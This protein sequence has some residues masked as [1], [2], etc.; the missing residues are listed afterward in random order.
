MFVDIQGDKAKGIELTEERVRTMAESRLRAARLYADT[1]ATAGGMI[2]GW[3]G[4]LILTLDDGPAFT[5]SVAYSKFL[6][7]PVTGRTLMA[8][9][10]DTRRVAGWVS[11]GVPSH[12]RGLVR[13]TPWLGP[14]RLGPR[15][16]PC[17]SIW[18]GG[19]LPR[20]RGRP[21]D[22]GRVI[23]SRSRG[24]TL[25]ATPS[26]YQVRS[27]SIEKLRE[28]IAVEDPEFATTMDTSDIPDGKWVYN[29]T[30]EYEWDE[31]PREV[32]ERYGPTF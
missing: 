16:C 20:P 17:A 30:W 6:R 14:V 22:P 12:E 25:R 23:A 24:G 1:L 18:C 27:H 8:M 4:I 19:R 9:T 7:D 28:R 15:S 3:L 26:T 5:T 11:A 21:H 29:S 13:V 10:W 32:R 2:N 31:E